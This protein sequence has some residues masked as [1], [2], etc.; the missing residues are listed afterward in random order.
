MDINRLY[1]SVLVP[2]V[3]SL[4]LRHWIDVITSMAEA[5]FNHAEW[6]SSIITELTHSYRSMDPLLV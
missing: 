1:L 6:R 4:R 2:C 5:T 3:S